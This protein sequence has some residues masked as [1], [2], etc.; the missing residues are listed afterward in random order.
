MTVSP[1]L[2]QQ[3]HLGWWLCLLAWRHL[4]EVGSSAPTRELFLVK[5]L[6]SLNASHAM[7]RT[8]DLEREDPCLDLCSATFHFCDSGKNNRD[9]LSPYRTRRVGWVPLRWRATFTGH[10]ES[11]FLPTLPPPWLQLEVSQ[12]LGYS[13]V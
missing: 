9:F 5:V 12:L 8:Q 13:R 3:H 4:A 6:G 7:E 10:A 11:L 2:E 1:V